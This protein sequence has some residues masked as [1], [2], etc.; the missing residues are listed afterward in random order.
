MIEARGLRK[1]FGALPALRDVDIDIPRGEV[2][3]IIGPNGAG[4]TTF[5][6]IVLGLVR[7]DAGTVRLDGTRGLLVRLDV[8]ARPDEEEPG[9]P[10]TD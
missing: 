6:K 4:K 7:P 1:S 2:T 10:A 8:A 9:E 5:N 3:A